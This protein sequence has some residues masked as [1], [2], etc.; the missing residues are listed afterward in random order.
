MHIVGFEFKSLKM[1]D[2]IIA[3]DEKE[4]LE[5]LFFANGIYDQLNK[6]RFITCNE[7]GYVVSLGN[8][9]FHWQKLK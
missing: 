9:I 1:R 2:C 5:N 3:V 6:R 4:I 7:D 8:C